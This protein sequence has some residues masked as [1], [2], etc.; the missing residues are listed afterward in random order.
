MSNKTKLIKLYNQSLATGELPEWGLCLA[1]LDLKIT[2][3]NI[4]LFE[5]SE[6]EQKLLKAKNYSVGF[7]G[8]GLKF[9]KKGGVI[10]ATHDMR[11]YKGFTPLRQ[12]I[13]GFLI[14]MEK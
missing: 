6:K 12:T 10:N 13:L 11:I 9:R 2:S 1:L 8:S 3:N 14:A 7:W 4:D 5:P